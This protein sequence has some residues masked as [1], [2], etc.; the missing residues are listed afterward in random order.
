MFYNTKNDCTSKKSA[1]PHIYKR[2]LHQKTTDDR[3]VL[4]IIA[5]KSES[6]NGTNE[7]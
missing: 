7:D 4:H 1:F 3:N 5:Q 6:P 2:Y